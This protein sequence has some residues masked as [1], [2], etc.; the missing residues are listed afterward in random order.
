M[1][2]R[3]IQAR[4]DSLLY[5]K[6][7]KVQFREVNALHILQTGSEESIFEVC[8]NGDRAHEFITLILQAFFLFF[9]I[10]VMYF[11]MRN[12]RMTVEIIRNSS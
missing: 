1:I 5:L 12:S 6:L 2:L 3:I 4:D 10:L 11:Y 9:G 7:W 8:P